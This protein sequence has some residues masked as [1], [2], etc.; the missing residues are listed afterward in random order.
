MGYI[1]VRSLTHNQ[2]LAASITL[3]LFHRRWYLLVLNRLLLLLLLLKLLRFLL[4]VVHFLNGIVGQACGGWGPGR[5]VVF[6]G[7]GGN[8]V[9]VGTQV[10]IRSVPLQQLHN[11]FVCHAEVPHQALKEEREHGL[12]KIR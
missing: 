1:K 11:H 4:I 2:V 6:V 5:S 9:D 12:E 8:G 10:V 7:V 3:L